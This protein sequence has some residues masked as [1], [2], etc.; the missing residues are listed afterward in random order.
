MDEAKITKIY[1]WV[2]RAYWKDKKSFHVP[3]E[4]KEAAQHVADEGNGFRFDGDVLAW[5]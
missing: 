4:Y 5:D 2:S 3:E 1:Y